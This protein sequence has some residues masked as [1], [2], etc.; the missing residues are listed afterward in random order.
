MLAEP[1]VIG[2]QSGPG[3]VQW[4]HFHLKPVLRA[5]LHLLPWY[6]ENVR[7]PALFGP[8]VYAETTLNV[9]V[10]M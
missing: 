1:L 2:F 9:S 3:L 10:L 6:L 5:H 7:T 8:L 4:L